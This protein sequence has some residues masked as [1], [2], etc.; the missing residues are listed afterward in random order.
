MGAPALPAQ[1]ATTGL[2]SDEAI[3][4][5]GKWSLD[6]AEG[7]PSSVSNQSQTATVMRDLRSLSAVGI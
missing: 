7:K 5:L 6:G 4:T 3:D 1:S 2:R